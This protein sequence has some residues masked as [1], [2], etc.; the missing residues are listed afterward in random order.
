MLKLSTAAIGLLADG[1]ATKLPMS[2]GPTKRTTSIR[3][4]S[5][6]CTKEPAKATVRRR[7]VGWLR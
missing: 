7:H 6:K 4:A 2:P 3:K 1:L 5:K